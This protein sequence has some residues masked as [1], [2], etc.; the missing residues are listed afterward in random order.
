MNLEKASQGRENNLD[1]IRFIAAILVI[2]CHAFPLALGEGV[3][4]PLAALTGDQIS[5]GSLAVGIFFVYGGFLICKSMCRIQKTVPYFKARILRIFPP[6][7]AVTVVL[8]F[9]V[10]PILT[11]LPLRDYYTDAGTYRYLLNCVMALQHQLP[12]VF[13]DNIYGR[14]VNGPLWTLPIEFICYIMCYVAYKCKLVNKKGMIAA[15]VIFS[16]GC[17]GAWILSAKITILAPMIRPMGLF[18]AGMLYY[19][20]RDKIPMK[21]WVAAVCFVGMVVSA[22]CHI[23]PVTIFFFFPYVILYLGFGTKSVFANFA[24]RGEIS[25]G[26]YLTAWPVQQIFAQVMCGADGIM[27]PYVNFLIAVPISIVLGYVVFKCV[28][29]PVSYYFMKK[30]K[31]K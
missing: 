5:F 11:Q 29:E 26:I 28:E 20:Y 6:L 1:I 4:D 23:L 10:G 17:I 15:T 14:A 21:G 13:L 12:G 9:V 3:L 16:A 30:G 7:I 8:A 22:V 25:Y 2:F 19:V 24:K 27:N 31:N 18:F